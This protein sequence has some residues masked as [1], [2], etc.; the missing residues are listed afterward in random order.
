MAILAGL[1]LDLV[2]LFGN[3]VI[4]CAVGCAWLLTGFDHFGGW[5]IVT[6]FV[7]AIL[8]EV[9][10]MIAASFGATKFG[11]SKGAAISAMIGCI[12]GAIVGSPMM[13][14]VGT[15]AG[16]CVGAFVAAA[17][18]E[19]AFMRKNLQGSVKTGFGA[20]LG[21][22]GGMLGKLLVGLLMLF[23]AALTY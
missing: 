13:P 6:L 17:A 11:G 5:A 16:A 4:L 21:K 12:A 7:L 2:G 20:A 9:V 14:L 18:Y 8:G 3:W 19:A 22:I 10:E 15:L 23:V 1:L